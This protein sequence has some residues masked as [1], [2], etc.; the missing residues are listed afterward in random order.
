MRKE[1]PKPR[2]VKVAFEDMSPEEVAAQQTFELPQR[3]AM[4]VASATSALAVGTIANAA[5]LPTTLPPQ[6]R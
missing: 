4:S 5:L 6:A 2:A 3:E 1:E